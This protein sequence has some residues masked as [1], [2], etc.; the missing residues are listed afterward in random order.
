MRFPG[1]HTLHQRLDHPGLLLP[2]FGD[3]HPERLDTRQQRQLFG[4]V[5]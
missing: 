4:T 3:E 1:E 5:A 2:G